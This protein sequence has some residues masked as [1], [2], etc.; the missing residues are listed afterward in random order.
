[1]V[2]NDRERYFLVVRT[3]EPFNLTRIDALPVEFNGDL[4]QDGKVDEIDLTILLE[5]WNS[6][7]GSSDL[8]NLFLDWSTQYYLTRS[9]GK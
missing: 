6:P 2:F 5:N 8:Q 1:M 3:R 9:F 4:N 7:W